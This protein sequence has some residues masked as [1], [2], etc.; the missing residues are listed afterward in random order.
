MVKFPQTFGN[1]NEPMKKLIQLVDYRKLD[2]GGNKVL[3]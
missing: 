1:Y 2:H 3:E